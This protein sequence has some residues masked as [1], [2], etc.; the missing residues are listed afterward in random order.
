[1]G[2]K[3]Y[4][5]TFQQYL[6]DSVGAGL[7]NNGIGCDFVGCDSVG[8][9]LRNNGIGSDS[10]GFPVANAKGKF[11]CPCDGKICGNLELLRKHLSTM[12]REEYIA[13]RELVCGQVVPGALPTEEQMV[14]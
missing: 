4:G 6:S 2:T 9:E 1:M 14:V 8:A 5:Q 3:L 13:A 10:V 7:R 12:H 11:V